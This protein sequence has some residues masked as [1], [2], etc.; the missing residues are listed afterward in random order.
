MVAVSRARWS[1]RPRYDGASAHAKRV[2]A[3]VPMRRD[4]RRALAVH[5]EVSGAPLPRRAAD[6]GTTP[7]QERDAASG[8]RKGQARGWGRQAR[9]WARRYASRKRSADTCV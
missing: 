8:A 1:T 5:A 4:R 2:N 7:R 9:G 3:P 6:L